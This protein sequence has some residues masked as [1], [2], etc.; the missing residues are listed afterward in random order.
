MKKLGM[1][2]TLLVILA[3]V[4]GSLTTLTATAGVVKLTITVSSAYVRSGPSLLLPRVT[5]IFKGET[6]T[7]LGRTADNIWVKLDVAGAPTETWTLA[8]IGILSGDLNSV[9][10][11]AGVALPPATSTNSAPASGAA[12]AG[13]AVTPAPAPSSAAGSGGAPVPGAN[14]TVTVK[15]VNLRAS[16]T[17]LSSK[18]GALYSGQTAPV[19]GRSADV[20]WLQVITGEGI[21]GWVFAGAGTLNVPTG[22]LPITDPTAPM[23][24]GPAPAATPAA[25]AGN[26]AVS[27]A[28]PGA[29]PV[30]GAT[31][32]VTVKS[33]NV[34]AGPSAL[35]SKVGALYSGQTAAVLGRSADVQWLQVTMG[36][37]LAGWVIASAGKL[38]VPTG[39]LPITDQPQPTPP[40]APAAGAT[41]ALTTTVSGALFTV[42]AQIVN[43]RASPTSASEKLSALFSGQSAPAVG[44]ST[45]GLWTQVANDGIVGWVIANAGKLNVPPETL[46]ITDR[47][48]PIVPVTPTDPPP[49]RSPEANL[50]PE[51]LPTITPNMQ[52]I[53]FS[54]RADKNLNMF[55]VAGDCNADDPDYL[56][57]LVAGRFDLTGYTNLNGTVAQ[58]AGGFARHSLATHGGLS[59]ATMFDA[60]WANPTYCRKSFGNTEGPLQ[61]E[62]R[63]SQASLVFLAV[64]TGDHPQWR[65]FEVNYRQMI[66]YALKDKVLPV[67]VTKA[68][69]IE[70]LVDGAPS[71][72]I[73]GIVRKLSVEYDVPLMDFEL[74][75]RDLPNHGL[76]KEDLPFHLSPAGFDMRTLFTLQMLA[77]I[78]GK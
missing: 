60:A 67:L 23:P 4:V 59:A 41:P 45:D 21:I 16:P 11:T 58:F 25:T 38:N 2:L 64:G 30:P 52:R 76:L 15:S 74:A 66:E 77:R 39:M 20:Q 31:F 7:I 43:L 28:V 54:Y 69:D 47:P 36:E 5:S 12:P 55:T 49:P 46:P 73:N 63:V 14:F 19:L 13:G 9:P 8:A 53:Y 18:V 29:V 56:V 57:R 48:L 62:L 26:V 75:T 51:W 37:G 40:A 6:Y 10:V 72:Y 71:G 24:A 32:A 34:R 61:C 1:R 78:S 50:R 68:D 22:M 44:R 3:A 17:T 70:A 27:G 65:T 35:S 33:V 42:S